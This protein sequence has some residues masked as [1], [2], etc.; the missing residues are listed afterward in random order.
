MTTEYHHIGTPRDDS[1]NEWEMVVHPRDV[2]HVF[3]RKD[4]IVKYMPDMCS[5]PFE[6]VLAG[7]LAWVHTYVSLGGDYDVLG[8]EG[9]TLMHY[10]V[11][12]NKVE[13]VDEL[14]DKMKNA[15][16]SDTNGVSPIAIAARYG[17]LDIVRHLVSNGANVRAVDTGGNTVVH[18]AARCGQTH[19]VKFF[20]SL[21]TSERYR[22]RL[23]GIVRVQ[24]SAKATA[25]DLALRAGYL[26]TAAL[27]L[28]YM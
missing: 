3:Y 27:I 10:A 9:R 20:F 13:I 8:P 2:A 28:T 12:A 7:D 17:H 24:N 15:H 19:I 22:D 11:A 23:G 26:D 21:F 5:S 18:E 4:E 14:F 1:E 6:A 25:Y 16:K